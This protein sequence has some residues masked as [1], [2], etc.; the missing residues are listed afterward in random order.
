M[1]R[2]EA[3]DIEGKNSLFGLVGT[4]VEKRV[5]VVVVEVVGDTGVLATAGPD[6]TRVVSEFS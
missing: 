5:V 3:R 1:S 4:G 2:W 6:Q